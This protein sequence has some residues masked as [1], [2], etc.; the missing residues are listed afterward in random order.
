MKKLLTAREVLLL[1]V[2]GILAVASSYM[3]MFRSPITNELDYI[4]NSIQT[5]NVKIES[6]SQRLEEKKR[7]EK[8]LERIFSQEKEPVSIAPY[9]NLKQV[10]IELNAVLAA[11]QE[12]TLSFGT[13]DAETD[14][15]QRKISLS[16]RSADYESAVG[17]LSRLNESEYRCMLDEIGRAH[18]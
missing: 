6:E 13:V 8:E 1:C 10:M 3:L 5:T 15:V 16:F 17:I 18:V 4:N 7:M 14:I 2:L 11:A 9:D 12:Y